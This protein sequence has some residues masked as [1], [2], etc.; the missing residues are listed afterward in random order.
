MTDA[1]RATLVDILSES[2]GW[3]HHGCCV[4]VDEQ[5]HWLAFE[6]GT[7]SVGHPPV[8]QRLMM[9]MTDD[10]L[11]FIH[12]HDPKPYHDRNRDIVD[13]C[14][15]LIAVPEHDREQPKGGTWYTVRYARQVEREHVIIWPDGR[16]HR[17]AGAS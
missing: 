17:V 14:E 13:A 9:S 2:I 1:Q 8:D 4:G 10:G 6:M 12:L 3:L 15:L 7:G 16:P 5:A 11:Q